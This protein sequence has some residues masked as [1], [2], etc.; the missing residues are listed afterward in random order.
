MGAQDLLEALG[1]AEQDTARN[2]DRSHLRPAGALLSLGNTKKLVSM[3][4]SLVQQR[5]AKMWRWAG[6]TRAIANGLLT[7]LEVSWVLEEDSR[8]QSAVVIL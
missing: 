2:V 7:H 6:N 5:E 3:A 4:R 8:A 1:W